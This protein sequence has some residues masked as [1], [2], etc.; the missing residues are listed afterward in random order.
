MNDEYFDFQ[1]ENRR[2]KARSKVNAGRFGTLRLGFD[3]AT[4]GFK[5]GHCHVYISAEPV[6]SGVNNRNH[7]PYCLWSKHLDLYQAGDRLAACKSLMRPVGLALKHTRKKYGMQ[8]AG[9]LMLVHLC[10]EC[11]R[12]SLNRIAADDDVEK[13]WEIYSTSCEKHGQAVAWPVESEVSMLDFSAARLVRAQLFGNRQAS[14]EIGQ[15]C[16]CI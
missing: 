12:M 11:G 6:L 3:P 1:L 14:V 5:C 9:E 10:I 8:A 16:E 15:P 13:I 7:C 4:T 2:V